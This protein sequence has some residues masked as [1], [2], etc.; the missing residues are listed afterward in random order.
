MQ[1]SIQNNPFILRPYVSKE[2]FCDRKI[3]IV[4]TW[5]PIFLFHSGLK[6]SIWI[7]AKMYG[8]HILIAAMTIGLIC[9][10]KSLFTF[11]YSSSFGTFAIYAS[12]IFVSTASILLTLLYI[13][14]KGMRG[15]I[16]RFFILLRGKQSL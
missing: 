11:D 12:I 13:S 4:L 9:V 3:T 6:R 14:E 15:F 1:G 10:I 5:K 8:V 7:Y 2:L 16:Q